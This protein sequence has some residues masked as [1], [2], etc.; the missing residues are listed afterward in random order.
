MD[1]PPAVIT[2]QGVYQRLLDGTFYED[3]DWASSALGVVREALWQP[4]ETAPQGNDHEGPFFDVMWQDRMHPYLP[5]P[6]RQIDCYRVGETIRREHGYPSMTTI[7][8][9]RPTHWRAR[10][11]I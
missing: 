9:P 4:I 3:Y 1:K 10:G 2:M 7:F 6:M 8:N 5:V 11:G